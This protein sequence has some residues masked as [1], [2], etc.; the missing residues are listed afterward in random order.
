MNKIKDNFYYQ[1]SAKER[2]T[3]SIEAMARDD[4]NEIK[5]LIKTCPK[6]SYKCNDAQYSDSMD[7]IELM[8]FAYEYDILSNYF[9]AIYLAYFDE[10]H[11]ENYSNSHNFLKKMVDIRTAWG[12]F[13]KSKHIRLESMDKIFH[14]Y[15]NPLIDFRLL[16][17]IKPDSESVNKILKAMK[18]A[19]SKIS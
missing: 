11:N 2:I 18:D 4:Q 12:E 10:M 13:L 3:A 14:E 19:Y 17:N 6:K 8:Q 1:L 16:K 9:N 7:I 5:K 15:R